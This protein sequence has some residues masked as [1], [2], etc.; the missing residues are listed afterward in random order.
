VL[1]VHDRTEKTAPPDTK[2]SYFFLMPLHAR[3]QLLFCF[4]IHYIRPLADRL[5]RLINGISALV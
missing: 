2:V 3:Q 4:H 5:R 1:L